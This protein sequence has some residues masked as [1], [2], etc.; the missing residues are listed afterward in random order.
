MNNSQTITG[1]IKVLDLPET[2]CFTSFPDLI[3]SLE[4]YLAVQ[5]PP[6]SFSNIVISNTQ[7]G[8]ADRDKIWWRL[9]NSGSFV[10]IYFYS[11][12]NWIQVFPAP[13]QIFWLYGDSA[14]PPTGFSFAAV[15]SLFSAPNYAT[16]IAQAIPAGPGPYVYYPAVYVGI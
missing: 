8:S 3:R 14:N 12:G 2:A 1:A 9:S 4:Q 16:L 6:Q 15:S 10:G 11:G 13:N 5:I 7:P